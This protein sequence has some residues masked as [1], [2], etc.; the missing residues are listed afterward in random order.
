MAQSGSGARDAHPDPVQR[1]VSSQFIQQAFIGEVIQA[2]AGVFVGHVQLNT[3]SIVPPAMGNA[4]H[5]WQQRVRDF[6]RQIFDPAHDRF[7]GDCL[8]V[9]Q[10]ALGRRRGA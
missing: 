1:G 3:G 6:Q 7:D 4:H 5:A 9:D 10:A 8:A 2:C